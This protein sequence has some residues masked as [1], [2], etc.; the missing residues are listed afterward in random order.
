MSNDDHTVAG[1]L[2]EVDSQSAQLPQGMKVYLEV[3]EGPDRGQK[4]EVT[5]FQTIIGRRD[6]DL[7]LSDPTVSSRHAV[8]EIVQGD[9]FVYD[10]ESTNGTKVNGEVVGSSPV[11]NMDEIQVGDTRILLSVIEDKYA[12]YEDEA[13]ESSGEILKPDIDQVSN[14]TLTTKHQV[15]P[16]LPANLQVALEVI[17]GPEK[18][19]AFRLKLK[20]NV[21]GRGERA[22]VVLE[23][24]AVSQQH[25]QIEIHQ[26]DKLTIKDLASKNGTKLNGRFISA[27]KLRD[28]D[29][30][31]IGLTSMR[32]TVKSR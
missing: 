30:I 31:E 15:N 3:T 16:E 27:V 9:I 4:I 29:K 32:L 2:Q 25:V 23:D 11:R 7:Q 26:K 13:P 18:G 17:D 5:K 21:L 14:D 22:D 19:K 10:E 8:L 20:S 1:S 24:E 28:G 12:M 6:V